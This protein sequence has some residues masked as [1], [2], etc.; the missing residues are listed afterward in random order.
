MRVGTAV[1]ENHAS[2][3]SRKDDPGQ[4]PGPVSAS[5]MFADPQSRA[6][7]N[8]LERVAPTGV[9]VLITGETGSGKERLARYIHERSGRAGEFVVVQCSALPPESNANTSHGGDRG[10][11]IAGVQFGR[12]KP[13][14]GTLFLDDVGELPPA[15]QCELLRLLREND[16]SLTAPD[17]AAWPAVRVITSTSTELGE[18]VLKGHFRR[19]LFYRLN[20]ATVKVLP[21][22]QR[23]GDI[24]PLANHF[25]RL[26]SEDSKLPA[27]AFGP[28]ALSALR[29]HSWPGNVRELENV[30]R[31]AVLTAARR[32]ISATDLRLEDEHLAASGVGSG[33]NPEVSETEDELARLLALRLRNPGTHLYDEVEGLLVAEAFRTTGGN[34]VHTALLLGISRN[35]V[36]TLLRKHGLLS[37]SR[38]L[39]R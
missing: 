33:P 21:L 5:P 13:G 30:V 34:Q 6:L 23:P 27:R 10:V 38:K 15:L 29:R 28:G 39:E 22:R 11:R 3:A 36:R 31:F 37:S 12:S 1:P 18:E 14:V 2:A 35:V 25:L 4:D 24:V 9:P 17:N 7:A 19:D 26:Y 20:I 32:E 16:A 8:L